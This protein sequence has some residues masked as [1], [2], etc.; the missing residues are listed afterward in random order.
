MSKTSE[1]LEIMAGFRGLRM[2]V[3]ADIDDGVQ[4]V[5]NALRLQEAL[6]WLVYHRLVWHD[7][8][9][10][11]GQAACYRARS[12]REAQALWASEGAA[13]A[14]AA[15]VARQRPAESAELRAESQATGEPAA[16]AVRPRVHAHQP[17]LFA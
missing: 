14:E 10:G 1:W 12:P 3:H 7:H 4:P 6:G 16:A 13:K 11:S 5:T 2:A 8:S 17:E 9:T 15:E